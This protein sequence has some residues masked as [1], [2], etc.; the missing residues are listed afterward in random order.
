MPR[1]RTAPDTPVTEE[2]RSRGKEYYRRH[3]ETI[4]LK[5][6]TDH[7]RPPRLS[8]AEA[9]AH[10]TVGATRTCNKCGTLQALSEFNFLP[11][12]RLGHSPRCK[13]CSPKPPRNPPRPKTFRSDPE[14]RKKYFKEWYSVNNELVKSRVRRIVRG[15]DITATE[16]EA[17]FTEQEGKCAICGYESAG[18]GHKG[19]YV[20][21]DHA[22]GA[23]RKLLCIHC[24][25]GLGHFKDDIAKL[26]KAIQYLKD[27]GKLEE[28][29]TQCLPKNN[30]EIP[31]W[32]TVSHPPL[33]VST[34]EAY[35]GVC[36]LTVAQ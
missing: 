32:A 5:R 36:P 35:S 34:R 10:E 6:K 20:D 4:L 11:Q 33:A 27:N 9:E 3:R 30:L 29:D 25:L 7:P 16:I 15:I 13:N 2:K 12:G 18:I 1:Q 28:T 21:H 17:K 23:I 26:Q 22:T 19:L 31:E 8:R 14:F 24:N